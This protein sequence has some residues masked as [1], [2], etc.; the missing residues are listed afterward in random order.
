MGRLVGTV[1]FM[2]PEHIMGDK[3][4]LRADLYSLG[5][6]LYM[7]LTGKNLLRQRLL[8]DIFPCISR[9]MLPTHNPQSQHTRPPQQYLHQAPPKR[10][11]ESILFCC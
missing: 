5:A 4:D 9:T 2:A 6:L 8:L 11:R 3:C 1:A 7:G 10:T